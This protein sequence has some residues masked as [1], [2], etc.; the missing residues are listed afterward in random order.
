MNF[1][2]LFNGLIRCGKLCVYICVCMCDVC[3]YEKCG[4][5]LSEVSG[6]VFRQEKR[7]KEHLPFLVK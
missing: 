6:C 7:K 5:S 3:I 2:L 1:W 4:W